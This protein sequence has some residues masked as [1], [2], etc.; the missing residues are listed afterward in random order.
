MSDVQTISNNNEKVNIIKD[1]DYILENKIGNDASSSRTPSTL[2]ITRCPIIQSETTTTTHAESKV[3]RGDYWYS[4][5]GTCK[6][7]GINPTTVNLDLR[8]GS[9]RECASYWND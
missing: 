1:I 2:V 4:I 3:P 8:C 9:N 7:C 5:E 6:V